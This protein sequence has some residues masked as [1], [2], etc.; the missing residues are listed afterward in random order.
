MKENMD[1]LILFESAKEKNSD[2]NILKMIKDMNKQVDEKHKEYDEKF[3]N[4]DEK[5]KEYDEKI[6]RINEK[7]ENLQ[8][9]FELSLKNNSKNDELLNQFCYINVH[10]KLQKKTLIP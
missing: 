4:Y 10:G 7:V 2:R 6:N 1:F 8:A 9:L 5:F 3:K